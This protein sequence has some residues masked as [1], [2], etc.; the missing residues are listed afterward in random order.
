MKKSSCIQE[1]Q[2]KFEYLKTRSI[3]HITRSAKCSRAVNK[4]MQSGTS[5]VDWWLGIKRTFSVVFF[6][7]LSP[8]STTQQPAVQFQQ[9]TI[10][11][12]QPNK[13]SSIFQKAEELISSKGE[14]SS[15]Q[16]KQAGITQQLLTKTH[17]KRRM[18]QTLRGDINHQSDLEK[19]RHH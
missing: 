3:I 16:A 19:S 2:P 12:N 15:S 1:T 8:D 14:K 5:A 7:S 11:S 13:T 17:K 6:S 10:L 9:A 18:L 4:V